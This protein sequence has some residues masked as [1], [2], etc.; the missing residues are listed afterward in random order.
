MVILRM[1]VTVGVRVDLFLRLRR[2]PRF[3][4]FAYVALYGAVE[5]EVEVEAEVEAEVEEGVAEMV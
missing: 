3:S 4:L 5:V 1:V 2:A